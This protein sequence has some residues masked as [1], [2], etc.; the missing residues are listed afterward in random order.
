M[1]KTLTA[2]TREID[3][4]GAAAA[5]IL[6]AID[7]DNSL[8]K[9][10][11]GIVSCFSD[12]AETGALKAV[13]DAMPFDIVGAT[14]IMGAAN[15]N[16]DQ[17]MLIMTVITSD[18]C[19]FK[20]ISI[21]LS[22]NCEESVMSAL[23]PVLAER[24]ESPALML[25]FLPL[26]NALGGD[27]MVEALD[28]AAGG[29]PMF[30]AT[31]IDHTLDYSTAFT[32]Y[33][34]E[35]LPSSIVLALVYGKPEVAYAA[36]TLSE[37][38][39]IS[40]KAIITGAE[41]NLL[42]EINGKTVLEYIKEIGLT[43]SELNA[44]LGIVPLFVG[45]ND[46]FISVVR[47]IL[48]LTPEGYVICGGAMPLNASLGVGRI[49]AGDVLGTTEAAMRPFADGRGVI[50]GYSCLAR[51]FALGSNSNAE[52][53]TVVDVGKD[54]RYHFAVSGGEV[55]PIPDR[56]GKLRNFFHNYTTVFCRLS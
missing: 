40:R 14:T 39:I 28:N 47:I 22:E 2:L 48:N 10:S 4:P 24:A 17:I 30:G 9:N 19:D 38:K 6:A 50:I 11:L 25:T 53:N 54:A 32:V 55:C 1:I 42:K 43:E 16:V 12:F 26:M 44:G 34:G 23:T 51:Y 37:D 41:G 33:N 52:A 3:D 13:C 29:V 45:L 15:G 49:N 21:P 31:A 7:P 36:A 18:D 56:E 8:L 35:P 27:R 20:S 46:G 5:E